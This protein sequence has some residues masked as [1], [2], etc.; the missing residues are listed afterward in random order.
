MGKNVREWENKCDSHTWQSP[1]VFLLLQFSWS[2]KEIEQNKATSLLLYPLSDRFCPLFVFS[3]IPLCF[4]PTLISL[5][6]PGRNRII[7]S[8]WNTWRHTD[9]TFSR[10]EN[11]ICNDMSKQTSST[12]HSNNQWHMREWTEKRVWQ[13]NWFTTGQCNIFLKDIHQL[14][15][16]IL[17]M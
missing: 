7:S 13:A 3:F 9:N 1:V 10:E 4:P 8:L 5:K 15:F 2:L 6:F 14:A 16:E 11:R 17:E 12:V